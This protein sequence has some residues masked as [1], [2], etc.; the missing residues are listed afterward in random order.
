VRRG[1]RRGRE[2]RAGCVRLSPAVCVVCEKKKKEKKEK[3]K[4]KEKR[5]RE[6]EIFLPPTPDLALLLI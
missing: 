6:K 1:R 5:K 2:E 3:E 4:E